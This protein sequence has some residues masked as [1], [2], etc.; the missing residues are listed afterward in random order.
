[1]YE[2]YIEQNSKE[3][4]DKMEKINRYVTAFDKIS[5]DF[6]EDF[7]F[8][9]ELNLSELRILFGNKENDPM[10]YWELITPEKSSYFKDKIEHVFD[11][12]LYEYRLTN[13]SSKLYKTVRYVLIFDKYS[14]ECVTELKLPENVSLQE[15]Q[16]IF[17]E[18]EENPRMSGRYDITPKE[19]LYFKEKIEHEFNFELY[20]YELASYRGDLIPD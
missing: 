13:D 14:G 4:I 11:F 17:G 9:E 16:A 8:H 12:N 15:L 1:M 19:S 10:H 5:G 6:W 2:T 20:D 7:E 3:K 18:D